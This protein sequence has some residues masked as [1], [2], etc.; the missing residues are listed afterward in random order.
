MVIVFDLDDTLYP[1]ISYVH[2]GFKKVAQFLRPLL[3][4]SSK[5]F[6]RLKKLEEIDR[7]QVFDRFLKEKKIFTKALLKQCVSIYRHHAPKIALYPD[8]LFC[9][10]KLSKKYPLYLVT[11]GNRLVQ[12]N[13]IQ[14]LHLQRWIKRTFCTHEHGKKAAK[15]SP[16]CFQ[17]ICKLEKVKP[18]DVV[19]IADNPWKDF[20]GIKPLGFQTVRVKT[21][22]YKNV[23]L[24]RAH[25]ADHT[26][27]NMKGL[28]K[29]LKK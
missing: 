29:W 8:A 7:N 3:G 14:A 12:R 18:E 9:L 16:F 19:Y 4:D 5:T 20:I 22:P 13:K 1:E 15:P 28:L 10:K 27:Q 24:N 17:K 11:D 25:E 21:G 6:Q 2:G 23:K 26:I